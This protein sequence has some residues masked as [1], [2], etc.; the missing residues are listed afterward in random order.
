M[1][2]TTY[3]RF[4]ESIFEESVS[5]HS[6]SHIISS[7]CMAIHQ[8][9]F[10]ISIMKIVSIIFSNQAGNIWRPRNPFRNNA[11]DS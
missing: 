9:F 6:K 2:Y 11:C 5:N 10:I 8:F 4:H 1:I 7:L 3:I